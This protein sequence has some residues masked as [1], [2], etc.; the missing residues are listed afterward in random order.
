VHPEKKKNVNPGEFRSA[1][2]LPDQFIHFGICA[3]NDYKV[4]GARWTGLNEQELDLIRKLFRDSL[5]VATE[6]Y[7]DDNNFWIR[8]IRD[9][10]AE[11]LDLQN[12]H[13]LREMNE[14]PV[15]ERKLFFKEVVKKAISLFRSFQKPS[16]VDCLP[17]SRIGRAKKRFHLL[18]I[19]DL[20][21]TFA[22]DVR[23][24]RKRPTSIA[25]VVPKSLM[26]SK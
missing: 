1:T 17:N 19:S 3:T 24:P 13:R 8:I 16:H 12:E 2:I 11:S 4:D 22:I 7:S 20:G 10:L 18:Y 15:E 14:K 25:K 9:C 23:K 21:T 26:Y 5:N 6:E